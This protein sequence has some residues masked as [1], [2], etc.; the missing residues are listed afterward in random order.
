MNRQEQYAPHASNRWLLHRTTRDLAQQ[1][2][3]LIELVGARE[4]T[5]HLGYI[6]QYCRGDD[7]RRESIPARETSAARSTTVSGGLFRSLNS[8]A[9]SL[10]DARAQVLLTRFS[11]TSL[12]SNDQQTYDGFRQAESKGD[13]VRVSRMKRGTANVYRVSP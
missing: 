8:I 1:F 5:E 7:E 4:A 11:S 2:M 6:A 13:K 10:C 3:R 12:R 9:T